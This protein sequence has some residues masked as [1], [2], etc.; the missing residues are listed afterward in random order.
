MAILTL[1]SADAGFTIPVSGS[2]TWSVYGTD[3]ADTIEVAAGTSATVSGGG[4]TDVI[5]FLGGSADYTVAYSGTSAVFT[6]TN[7]S[8]VTI[9]LTSTG[10]SVAFG[11]GTAV[12]LTGSSTGVLLG[13]QTITTTAAAVTGA[14]GTGTGGTPATP[15]FSV[16][17]S[18]ASVTEGGSATF[19]V[20]L[21]SAQATA[22]TVTYALAGTGGA[23]LG[24]DTGTHV[25]AGNTGLL[26][27][28]PGE[29]SKTVVV[30]VTFDSVV[31]TGEGMTLTL[32]APSTGT[33][34]S[35]SATAAVAFA[36]PVAP[37]FT[38]TSNAVAGTPTQEGNTITFTITPSGIVDKDT[39]LL[40][41][42]VGSEVG[43]ITSKAG[44]SD[45]TSAQTVTFLAG[46]TAARTTSITVVD[47]STTEGIEGYKAQLLNSSSVEVGST[48]GLIND[49]SY[50]Y[51]LTGAA[52]VDEGASITYT[53]TAN[54]VAPTGGI[55]IPYTITGN[56]TAGTDF[57]PAATTGTIT[58]AAG[59]TT[60]TVTLNATAD[61]TTEATAENIVLTLGTPSTGNV[62]TGTVTTVVNDVSQG[63]TAGQIALSSS[64][65]TVDEGGAV[66]YTVT[67]GTAAPVGGLN[68]A[69]TLSGTATTVT[70]YTG[71]AATTGNIV[72]AAGATTG[73][74]TITTLAD[75]TTEGAETV[76]N[77]ITAPAGYT[78]VTGKNTTTTT[79]NDTSLTVAGE[80]KSLTTGQDIFTGTAGD[81]TYSGIVE[82]IANGGTFNSGDSLNG[83]TG[84]TDILNLTI[85]SAQTPMTTLT[86]IDKVIGTAGVDSGAISASTWT[87]LSELGAIGSTVN[88]HVEVTNLQN[89][90]TLS[91]KNISGFTTN[92]PFL[93]ATF[94]SGK[95][96]STTGTLSVLVD[97]VG[98]TGFEPEI[99]VT[100]AGTDKFT[101]IDIT[102]TNSN[103]FQIDASGAN[104]VTPT[105]LIFK[106][107]GSVDF[108]G[109]DSGNVPFTDIASVDATANSGGVTVDLN[110]STKDLTVTGGSGGDSFT[111]SLATQGKVTL[112]AG[113][114]NDTVTIDNGVA[115]A[116][117]TTLNSTDSINGGD[118]TSDT[119]VMH[120]TTFD[121]LADDTDRSVITGF[122]NLRTT[123]DL[124]GIT[125]S[126]SAFGI[127]NLQIGGTTTT[128]AATV[129]GFS[130]GATVTYRAA[131]DSTV[132]VN[133]G[134]TGATGANTPNDTLN[135]ALNSDLVA[136]SDFDFRLGVDGINIFNVTTSDR[137]NTNAATD[138]TEGYNLILSNDSNVN[139]INVSGTSM[140]AYATTATAT[141]LGYIN[142]GTSFSGDLSV[143]LG[144]FAGTQGV[145][146]T[147]GS[148]V[149]I[150]YG[151]GLG[152]ALTGGDGADYLFGG[153]GTD[154]ISGGSGSDIL[155]GDAGVDSFTGGSGV[156]YFGLNANAVG[157]GTS[158]DVISDFNAS[159]DKIITE[160]TIATY[161]SVG[162][163]TGATLATAA[164]TAATSAGVDTKTEAC[165]F[166]YG[167][168]TYLLIDDN[169][170][171]G[172]TDGTDILA[173]ITNFTGTLTAAS[174]TKSLTITGTAA[175]D[176]ITGSDGEDAITGGLGADII[177]G[178]AGADTITLGG[179]ANDNIRQTVI[180]SATTDGSASTAITGH[181]IITQFDANAGD[182]TDDAIKIGGTLATLINDDADATID[183]VATD[184]NDVGNEAI[185]GAANQ[186]AT[187]LLDAEVEIVVADLTTAGHANL[188]AELGEEIDFTGIATG[189]EHLFIVN[190]S[191]TQAGLI[192]YTA[193]TGGDDVIADADIQLL[194]IITHNDGTNLIA[195]DVTIL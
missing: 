44:A 8:T 120:A 65:T 118:G 158:V 96:G 71:S 146:V 102:A 111:A 27:F 181:D 184:G 15:T 52:S 29:V 114:G 174:F 75:T 41:N 67:L 135:V 63:L 157:A 150:V 56:A 10:D 179:S 132:A 17:A 168:K 156:D 45:F 2:A 51:V 145:S 59:A 112:N 186:E 134:M 64:A 147:T 109:G 50:T 34:L 77:T 106:G 171:A 92:N 68:V 20:S 48:T 58:I 66:T 60:G 97:S 105:S 165:T 78:M 13:T 104:M 136:N 138:R 192:L 74:L 24:T 28:A 36:D 72:I 81:D 160:Q 161:T 54:R 195:T 53:V 90:V 142:A 187:C 122:E 116:N 86:N 164:G 108:A 37:T 16:A 162:T 22:T 91:G 57:T 170:T 113:A 83:G 140:F 38:L 35:A 194:G 188:L 123:G 21:S 70:D 80:T 154:Q 49:P 166:V 148:A 163:V 95:I 126:I 127:N 93:K 151:T 185:V 7:G 167:S 177:T 137:T 39:T 115:I 62:T 31:E 46:E 32:S 100:T 107:T 128:G 30:P 155:L 130:S 14:T 133:V 143:D 193:G 103:N 175:A 26:T 82:T 11:D 131:A 88:A 55:T 124:N 18:A 98:T 61:N 19:T 3:A 129:N 5:H 42:L 33:A 43:S 85:P 176:R 1:T 25:P 119:V 173:D 99:E 76:I 144:L 9:P 139:T 183:Y 94:Q 172:F 12:L 117:T 178:G 159:E 182:A 169:A 79:I 189:Q 84:G 152:D 149:S 125:A 153:A 110:T 101:T 69:Y 87:G 89:N 191:A 180:F 73:T 23:V 4:G 190:V 6:H 121:N 40:V 47:D 141:G